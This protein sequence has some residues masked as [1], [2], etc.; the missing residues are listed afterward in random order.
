MA[1]RFHY[2][3]YDIMPKHHWS[4]WCVGIFPTRSDLP[5]LPRS[6]LDI[7]RSHLQDAVDEAKRAIDRALE[8]LPAKVA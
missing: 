6:T 2:R 7:L 3:G 4:S 8:D 1:E 5:L